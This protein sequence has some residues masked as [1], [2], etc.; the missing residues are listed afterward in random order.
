MS[1]VTHVRAIEEASGQIKQAS[2][3][4]GVDVGR[5]LRGDNSNAI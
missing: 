4:A 5:E 3:S 1:G 2:G